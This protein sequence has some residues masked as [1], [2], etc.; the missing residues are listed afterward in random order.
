[1]K[2]LLILVIALG[3]FLLPTESISRWFTSSYYDVKVTLRRYARCEGSLAP[4]KKQGATDTEFLVD[5][6]RLFLDQANYDNEQLANITYLMGTICRESEVDYPISLNIDVNR[7]N[8]SKGKAA[9]CKGI[10]R[11]MD[12]MFGVFKRAALNKSEPL[13]FSAIQFSSD[14]EKSP[15]DAYYNLTDLVNTLWISSETMLDHTCNIT[16]SINE[17]VQLRTSNSTAQDRSQTAVSHGYMSTL[18][19]LIDR[20]LDPILGLQKRFYWE[21]TNRVEVFYNG[22][23]NQ[24]GYLR[25]GLGKGY[26][27]TRDRLS[28]MFTYS[29]G[30]ANSTSAP[31]LRNSSSA[32]A[33]NVTNV[34][35]L[36]PGPL[37]VTEPTN[38]PASQQFN[39]TVPVL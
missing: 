16:K 36:P 15:Q 1:M 13:D 38:L 3:A 35:P 2:T 11:A 23:G 9:R 19:D 27:S 22:I 17:Y 37:N 28:T 32:A 14:S 10:D 21:G 30:S 20:I 12:A 8:G 4:L 7:Y 29:Y 34:I 26:K 39:K 24:L 33:Q 6:I 25:D 31:G 18:L 5:Q